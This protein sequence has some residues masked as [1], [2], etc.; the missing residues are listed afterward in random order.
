V[1]FH[2]GF[3]IEWCVQREIERERGEVPD[4]LG[5]VEKSTMAMVYNEVIR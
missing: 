2:F 4:H 5:L 3:L 1:G